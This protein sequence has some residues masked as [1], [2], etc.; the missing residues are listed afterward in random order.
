MQPPD[1][2]CLAA[3]LVEQYGEDACSHAIV[4]LI[5][6]QQS[7]DRAGERLYL[8]VVMIVRQLLRKPISQGYRMTD[9]VPPTRRH[10]A[11]PDLDSP[12]LIEDQPNG[13]QLPPD[14]PSPTI[15]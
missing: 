6:R 5:D 1:P 14:I 9:H 12:E 13:I 4:S 11:I 10:P 2:A 15:H 8:Q 3:L 7:G